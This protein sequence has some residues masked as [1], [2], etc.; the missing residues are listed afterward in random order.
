V[1]L[2]LP[3]EDES[4]DSL[5]GTAVAFDPCADP[6]EE[7]EVVVLGRDLYSG[8]HGGGVG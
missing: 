3:S 5:G 6:P 8:S 1:R 4:E 2:S 7:P